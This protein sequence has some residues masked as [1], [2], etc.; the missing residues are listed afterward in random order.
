MKH[1]AISSLCISACIVFVAGCTK[2]DSGSDSSGTPDTSNAAIK[3]FR[4]SCNTIFKGQEENPISAKDA[5][6]VQ[7]TV[8]GPNL[9]SMK[10]KKGTQLI[11]LHGLDVPYQTETQTKAEAL[12]KTLSAEG[13]AYFYP[14]E[15]DCT[16]TLD[17]GTEGA[18][19]ALFSAKGKSFS[20]T[21]LKNGLG[22]PT[23]DVC[24]GSK[25][26]SCYR[27][28]AEEAAPTPTPY[29]QVQGPAQAAGFMLWKPVA[30]SDGRLAIHSVPYGSTVVVEGEQGR[31]QGAGN[32]YGSLARFKKPGCSY[33]RSV[34]V[35]LLLSDGTN[36][37]FGDNDFAVVP[38]GCRRWLID[39][40]GNAKADSKQ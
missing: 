15:P 38:D 8:V 28:L 40:N 2:P 16:V 3:S 25:I 33:G 11:K 13:D 32:G 31:N 20:E 4:T 24:G 29:P 22:Q 39:K 14:A 37:M 10:Q 35:E 9:L 6:K 12:L 21:L 26:S 17:D 30:A 36:Y 34:R 23:S 7:V 19:G 1:S 18:V 5:K 27:A